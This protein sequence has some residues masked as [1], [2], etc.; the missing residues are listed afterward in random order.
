MDSQALS[1]MISQQVAQGQRIAPSQLAQEL[2]EALFPVI[3][4]HLKQQQSYDPTMSGGLSLMYQASSTTAEFIREGFRHV[5]NAVEQ[6][7]KPPT[8][9]HI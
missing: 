3:L 1:K 2:Y 6:V 9:N 5:T 4:A 7:K 8:P